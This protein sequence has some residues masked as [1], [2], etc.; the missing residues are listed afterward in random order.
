MES[1]S[2]IPNRSSE[3]SPVPAVRDPDHPVD[4]AVS[5]ARAA[6]LPLDT[7]E[8]SEDFSTIILQ[9]MLTYVGETYGS[10]AVD[11]IASRARTSTTEIS[12][13]Y[14]W[15][16]TD[17]LE[18]VLQEA[19]A[20]MED[21][22]E[23]RMACAYRLRDGYGAL[24][25]L[26]LA[27]SVRTVYELG[28]R[29]LPHICRVGSYEVLN[30]TRS[31]LTY[32]Y[33]A[34]KKESRLVCI[35]RQAA[36]QAI[37]TIW[38][39][40]A[41]LLEEGK[42]VSRGDDCCEYH[43]RWHDRARL[44]PSVFGAGVG[45]VIALVGSGFGLATLSPLLAFAGLGGTLG[46]IW[47]LRRTNRVNLEYAE[48]TNRGLQ[49][50]AGRYVE[51]MD[52][53]L[54]WNKRERQWNRAMAAQAV[55]RQQRF[56]E[57][58]D[59]ASSM[60]ERRNTQVRSF[61]HDMR[62]PLAVLKMGR[63]E[64]SLR[65]TPDDDEGREILGEFDQ[66]IRRM[67]QLL[68][69]FLESS[70]GEGDLVQLRRSTLEV[71]PLTDRLRRRAKVHVMHRDIRVAVFQTREAPSSIETDEVVFDR[72]VDNL[73]TNAARYT[74]SGSIVVELSGIPG[75]L[76]VK[77]SDTGIGIEPERMESIFRV[78]ETA[79]R[80]L[81][82]GERRVESGAYGLGLPIVV[83]LLDQIGGRL[84]VMSKVGRGTTFRA[85][86][87]E[88]LPEEPTSNGGEPLEEIIRRVVTIKRSAASEFAS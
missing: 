71:R 5:G 50:L 64:F 77:V 3:Q 82:D 38:G 86:F 74:D 83:R 66:A 49:E 72:V 46:M 73:L 69:D 32:R 57:A 21:E 45:S 65:L 10:Q 52:E 14:N 70:K 7:F 59:Q 27:A 40:P 67:E 33:T 26:M 75:F 47:E 60:F 48:E 78:G 16:S 76:E 4:V 8:G 30:A 41:A 18:V 36:V 31:S 15:I 1:R 9:P 35:S 28:A 34:K 55:E 61:S 44:L 88:N 6:A 20:L 84:Q 24:G 51:T 42:C 37:P 29:T 58:R 19:R 17:Q 23:F 11:L 56:D 39:L 12:K 79:G 62:N 80:M 2:T 53:T 81:E 85:Y 25:F 87:P 13:K 63:E 68:H 22:H 54:Q 43:L